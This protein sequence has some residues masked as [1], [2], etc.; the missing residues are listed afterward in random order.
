LSLDFAAQPSTNKGAKIRFGLSITQD[1]QMS[2]QAVLFALRHETA[3]MSFK[4]TITALTVLNA[5]GRRH[6]KLPRR[7]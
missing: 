2:H 7:M 3:N 4:K 6:L 1:A 5:E